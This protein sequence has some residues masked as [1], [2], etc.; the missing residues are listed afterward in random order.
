MVAETGTVTVTETVT[1]TV[2]VM[3]TE[4]ATP[5]APPMARQRRIRDAC[6]SACQRRHTPEFPPMNG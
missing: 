1:E 2:T 5:V 3:A 6:L 4:A